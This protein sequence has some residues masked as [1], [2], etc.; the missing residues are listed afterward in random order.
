MCT[1]HFFYAPPYGI[2]PLGA[3]LLQNQKLAAMCNQ[4]F[5]IEIPK[6]CHE[7]WNKMTPDAKGA[8]CGSCVKSVYDFTNKTD[9]EIADVFMKNKDAK[10]CGRFNASQVSK[11]LDIKIPLNQ[12]P[13]NVSPFRAFALA[14]FLVFGTMLF[15]CKTSTGQVMGDFAIEEPVQNNLVKG[16]TKITGDTTFNL[17]KMP[18][19][20]KPKF[21][22]QD[23]AKKTTKCIKPENPEPKMMGEMMWIPED[24]AK[25]I[26]PV[27]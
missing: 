10:I 16:E 3:S 1:A 21:T 2:S 4:K 9:D 23:T 24:T 8:F 15:S 14:I 17:E 7:D 20:G 5:K 27:T 18:M 11:P 12:L 13:R 25:Q 19:M 22:P 6:P 26:P